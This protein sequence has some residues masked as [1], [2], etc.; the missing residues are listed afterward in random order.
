MQQSKLDVKVTYCAPCGYRERVT[1][2]TA[3]ILG[4]TRN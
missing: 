2:L 1:D 4:R 3:E